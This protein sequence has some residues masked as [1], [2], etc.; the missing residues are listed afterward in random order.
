MLVSMNLVDDG[1]WCALS[2]RDLQHIVTIELTN[3]QKESVEKFRY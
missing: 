3:N 1:Q 2:L